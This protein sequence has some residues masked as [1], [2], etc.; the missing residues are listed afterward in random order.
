VNDDGVI[1]GYDGDH[2]ATFKNG[3]VT[4][5][6]TP[7]NTIRSW[8]SD[9]NNLGQIVGTVTI[10]SGTGQYQEAILWSPSGD[11]TLLGF[12]DTGTFSSAEDI[13]NLGQVV[14]VASPA[15]G[16][17]TA[18]IWEESAGLRALPVP[19]GPPCP[20]GGCGFM[21]TTSFAYAINDHGMVAGNINYP[22][23]PGI[24]VVWQADGAPVFLPPL[25]PGRGAGARDIN[26]A[27]TVVG[28]GG[29]STD[30]WLHPVAW[31]N[32]LPTDLGSMGGYSASANEINDEGVIVGSMTDGAGIQLPYVWANSVA[33]PLPLMQGEAQGGAGAINS[34]GMI[35]GASKSTEGV[36]Q[37]VIWTRGSDA[38]P[39]VIWIYDGMIVNATSPEGAVVEFNPP[40]TDDTDPNPSLVCEPSSG[41]LFPLEYTTVTCT[42]TDASGNTA[43]VGFDVYVMGAAEQLANLRDSVIGVGPGTSL[44]DKIEQAQTALERGAVPDT[45]RILQAFTLQVRALSGNRIP[46][47]TATSLIADA[48]RITKVLRY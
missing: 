13:N 23:Q 30:T 7:E 14:G 34:A 3:T 31:I 46:E 19:P 4:L 26:N 32:G 33:T 37:P 28:N 12:L 45:Y 20:P 10:Q 17:Y 48:T 1:V 22:Y 39:P 35:V 27:G 2:A 9:I 43:T 18:C 15:G 42:A 47:E 29:V 16:T 6:S 21:K 8:A 38:T 36:W 44:Q 24:A 5:L 25:A 41:T 40:V 11:Y